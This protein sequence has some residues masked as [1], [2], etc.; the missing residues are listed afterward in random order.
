MPYG[1]NPQTI[2]NPELPPIPATLSS[3]DDLVSLIIGLQTSNIDNS[4]VLSTPG[5]Q[6]VVLLAPNNDAFQ[7]LANILNAPIEG[8]LSEP[9][10]LSALLS[11]HVITNGTCDG[12]LMGTVATLHGENVV[13]D[14]NGMVTDSNGNSASI[15][16]II[17]SS[18]GVVAV[19]DKILLPVGP[20]N[21]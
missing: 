13:F 2:C 9:G 3:R 6:P 16:E 21:A 17:Q 20:G 10:L 14:S 1:G 18:N 7:N 15:L 5:N 4:G 8:L 11:Y 19:I 12:Q